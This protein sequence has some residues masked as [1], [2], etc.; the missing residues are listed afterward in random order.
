[1]DPGPRRNNAD[2]FLSHLLLTCQRIY[3]AYILFSIAL[4]MWQLNDIITLEHVL[5]CILDCNSYIEIM[6]SGTIVQ[7]PK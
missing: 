6:N 5:K 3:I 1:M 4:G 7:L 2:T